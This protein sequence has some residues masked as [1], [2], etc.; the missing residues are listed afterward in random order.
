MYTIHAIEIL[1]PLFERLAKVLPTDIVCRIR[2]NA[3]KARWEFL[4]D[5]FYK[6][7]S[8]TVYVDDLTREVIAEGRYESK[9]VLYDEDTIISLNYTT[10]LDYEDRGWAE[11]DA[12]WLPLLIANGYVKTVTET[13]TRI[14][15]L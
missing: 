12:A 3:E 14:V 1:T 5:G 7:G 11:P 8:M 13:V 9:D 15:K 4:V 10:W 6:H 2:F